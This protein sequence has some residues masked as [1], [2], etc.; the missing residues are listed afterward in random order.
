A[1]GRLGGRGRGALRSGLPGAAKA[2]GLASA[3]VAGRNLVFFTFAAIVAYQR[4]I[5]HIVAGV[6]ETD[7]SGYPDCRDDTV[8]ALQTAVNLGMESRAVF[9]TP[10]VWLRQAAPGRG[11]PA[12]RGGAAV[13]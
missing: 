10:L 4:N 6:C 2:Q 5:K 3:F 11:A 12:T 1:A 13:R 7:Y 8:K 9:H